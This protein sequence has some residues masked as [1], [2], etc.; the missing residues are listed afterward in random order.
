MSHQSVFGPRRERKQWLRNYPHISLDLVHC[1]PKGVRTHLRKLVVSLKMR[2]CNGQS[3]H[4][5]SS[6]PRRHHTITDPSP[7]LRLI[8]A[9]S[10]SHPVNPS[11]SVGNTGKDHLSVCQIAGPTMRY[12]LPAAERTVAIEPHGRPPT[13]ATSGCL[14]SGTVMRPLRTQAKTSG[15]TLRSILCGSPPGHSTISTDTPRLCAACSTNSATVFRW[16]AISP[17]HIGHWQLQKKRSRC[18]FFAES[19]ARSSNVSAAEGSAIWMKGPVR[20]W[21]N[22]LPSDFIQR[23]RLGPISFSNAFPTKPVARTFRRIRMS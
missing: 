13:T 21:M 8:F 20:V 9:A 23:C 15:V 18:L 10:V 3:F 19:R 11:A 14:P 1:T 12:S 4:Q 7:R 16:Q 2:G 5:F 6:F 22:L 17:S